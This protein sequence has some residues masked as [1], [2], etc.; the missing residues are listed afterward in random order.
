MPVQ[1]PTAANT[2]QTGALTSWV[3][4]YQGVMMAAAIGVAT[5]TVAGIQLIGARLNASS[6]ASSGFETSK[7]SLLLAC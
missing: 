2:P 4:K 1:I 7:S 3:I 6:L 5:K